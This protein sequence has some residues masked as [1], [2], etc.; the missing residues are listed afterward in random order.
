LEQKLL[1]VHFVVV[2]ENSVGCKEKEV[3]GMLKRK[4]LQLQF[5]DLNIR[6]KRMAFPSDNTLKVIVSISPD[7]NGL[8]IICS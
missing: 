2:F 7:P 5:L 3:N 1:M 4:I 8:L 6:Q